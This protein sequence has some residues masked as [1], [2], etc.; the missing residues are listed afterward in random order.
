M[1]LPI[2]C[3]SMVWMKDTEAMCG[4]GSRLHK[5]FKAKGF[6]GKVREDIKWVGRN[7]IRELRYKGGGRWRWISSIRC[8]ISIG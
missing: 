6:R 3:I 1:E 4:I 2:V 7:N 5:A 8:G